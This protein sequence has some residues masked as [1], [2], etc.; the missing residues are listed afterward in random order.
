[1]NTLLPTKDKS[2]GRAPLTVAPFKAVARKSRNWRSGYSFLPRL[3][4]FYPTKDHDDQKFPSLLPGTAP[5][6]LPAGLRF[7]RRRDPEIPVPGLPGHRPLHK[8]RVLTPAFWASFIGSFEIVCGLLL[9]IGWLT[10]LATIPPLIVMA[11]LL[12]GAGNW[13][14]DAKRTR[15]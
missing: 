11:V 6:A 9:S 12:I 7:P 8:A 13:S 15:I 10:R 2:S 1:M 14:V 3:L 5:V 4:H